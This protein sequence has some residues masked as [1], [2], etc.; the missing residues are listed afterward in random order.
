MIAAV[1]RGREAPGLNDASGVVT[2]SVFHD[3]FTTAWPVCG[4]FG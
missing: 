3:C 1:V 2:G 4:P